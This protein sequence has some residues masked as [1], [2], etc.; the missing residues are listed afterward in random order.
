MNASKAVT[1]AGTGREVMNT[2]IGIQRRL[3]FLAYRNQS[4]CGLPVATAYRLIIPHL[5]PTKR[6]KTRITVTT[7]TLGENINAAVTCYTLY[8]REPEGIVFPRQS[9]WRLL[10]VGCCWKRPA[11]D[12]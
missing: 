9:S 11:A 6:E 5:G 3:L 4:C 2:R 8:G 1:C 7:S 12:H 10:C